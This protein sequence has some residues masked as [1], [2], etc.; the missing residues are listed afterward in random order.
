MKIKKCSDCGQPL[1]DHESES[2]VFIKIMLAT[3]NPP[4][5]LELSENALQQLRSIIEKDLELAESNF[6]GTM[7]EGLL[8]TKDVEDA[9]GQMVDCSD[10][11][12]DE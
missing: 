12:G 9:L 10:P 1:M 7:V 11:K 3:E 8:L 5:R 4:K 2:M 6:P